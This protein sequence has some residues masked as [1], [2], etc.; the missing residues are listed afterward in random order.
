MN[1]AN[2]T[3]TPSMQ[4]NRVMI[5]RV[6][7]MLMVALVPVCAL[8]AEA[9]SEESGVVTGDTVFDMFRGGG[10]L[11]WPILLCSVVTLAFVLER[12]VALRQSV[13]FPRPL[14][15]EIEGLARDGKL[16]EALE[17]SSNEQSPFAK[18]VHACL[19]R[20]ESTGFEMEA[21]LEEAG[22]RAL[23]DLRKNAKP[24][25]VIADVAP[26]LGLMGTVVGMIKAFEV[27]AKTGALGQ[28]EL[29]AQGIS[30]ALL[31]T[32]FGLG[33]AVPALISFHYFRQKAETHVRS[34]EDS[35]LEILVNLRKHGHSQ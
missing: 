11:M 19:V 7:V 21:A 6:M 14:R 29:L 12:F 35:C 24:L 16:D 27:V 13:V 22:S 15:S 30:E 32:A 3:L 2:V 1:C 4:R 23:Y 28:T 17:L 25:G 26:L 20:A 10:Y 34:M 8:C 31:T 33:V 5:C 9:F 18:L